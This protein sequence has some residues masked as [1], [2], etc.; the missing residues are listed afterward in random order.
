VLTELSGAPSW[1]AF[2][3]TTT[4]EPRLISDFTP[5]RWSTACFTIA[6]AFPPLTMETMDFSVL[7]LMTPSPSV[8][9]R[10]GSQHSI[11]SSMG[12]RVSS[13]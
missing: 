10:Y 6:S 4:V 5:P 3:L 7:I 11:N 8:S 2:G 13:S 1:P 9:Q 12:Q